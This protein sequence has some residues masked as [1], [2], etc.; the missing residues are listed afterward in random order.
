MARIA[1]IGAGPSGCFTAQAL[2]KALPDA[3][4]DLFDALPV[5]Y[6]LV[7]YGVAPDHQGTKAVTRQFD[8]LFERQGAGFFGNVHVGRDLP[9]AALRAAYD[10]VV[11]ATGLHEDRALGV[12][13]DALP[14]VVGAGALTRA[15][16]D[17]PDAGPMP[18]LGAR[19]AVIGNGNVALDV[20][21]LLAKRAEE[22]DGSDLAPAREAALA[23]AGIAEITVIGRGPAAA[24]RFDPVMLRELGRLATAS[25][26][27]EGAT[28][29]GPV[30]EAL[31]A[32][33]GHAPAGATRQIR[34]R[35]ERP[36]L[37]VEGA[38]RVTGLTLAGPDGPETLACDS[39]V[40]AIGFGGPGA[41]ADAEGCVAPG[42]YAAGWAR[43][44]PRGTIPDNRADAQA[45]AARI[46]ADLAAAPGRAPGAE[47]LGAHLAGAVGF[48]G[49]Q[50]IDAAE[51][52]AAPAGRCRQKFATRAAL[53]AAAQAKGD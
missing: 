27:A 43:R 36:V 51:R 29:A 4:V 25:I 37:R 34:F 22:F 47:A 31:A 20:V 26:A 18:A 39:V 21:R 13:G 12:P 23:A 6:G 33:D 50:R 7:R 41:G 46:A 11:L 53:L 35:F 5:P 52:A 42:L 32:I 48:D 28:G 8:R 24:A 49:W 44:G 30:A 16:N 14:G 1:I 40:T 9:L 3:R 38:G 2:L 45:L 19:V 17:H 10:A 15:L